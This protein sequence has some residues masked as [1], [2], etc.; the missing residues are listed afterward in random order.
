M[1]PKPL[2]EL[3]NIYHDSV[4]SNSFLLLDW[5]PDQTGV[6]PKE[7]IARYKEFGDFVR[8]C[9]GSSVSEENGYFYSDIGLE[10]S[11]D[12]LFDRLVLQEDIEK[13]GQ[14]VHSF[15]ITILTN[16]KS[17]DPNGGQVDPPEREVTVIPGKV[18]GYKNI[19]ILSKVWKGPARITV[20]M[21]DKS[22]KTISNSQLKSLK[23]HNCQREFPN[24]DADDFAFA[25]GTSGSGS[26]S[27]ADDMEKE[28]MFA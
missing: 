27:V 4:G 3:V 28:I 13:K 17:N 23:A 5:T 25:T 15:N 20:E 8:G 21:Y 10:V 22:N 14:T 2:Q 12:Y 18:I 26:V 6:V 9:Y 19:I 16:P 1:K 11:S 24:T 7:H